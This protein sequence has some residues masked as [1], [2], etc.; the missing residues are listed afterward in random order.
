MAKQPCPDCRASS[1]YA[2][3]HPPLH[4]GTKYL[5]VEVRTTRMPYFISVPLHPNTDPHAIYWCKAKGGGYLALRQDSHL[6]AIGL[7]I[8]V[9][10]E[11]QRIS[12]HEAIHPG[13]FQR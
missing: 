5:T 6:K 11:G 4:P 7:H 10:V 1:H 9:E 2:V 8:V 12:I 13:N 3:K